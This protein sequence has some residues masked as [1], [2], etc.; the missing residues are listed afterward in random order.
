[1]LVLGI[2]STCD[3]TGCAIVRDGKEILSNVVASQHDIHA[4]YGGVFPELAS[5]RH[6]EVMIPVIDS[7]LNKA[8]IS[9]N[10]VDLIAVAHGP[11]LLGA[12][13]VG[14]NAAKT[15][16]FSL[17][18][19]FI[20]INHVEAHIYAAIMSQHT[21]PSLPCL[22]VILSGA[23]TSIIYI[24]EIGSYELLAQTTDDAIGEAFDKVAKVMDIPYPGGPKI[25]ALAK[26]GDPQSYPLKAGQVKGRPLDFSFSGIKTGVLYAVKGQNGLIDGKDK[27]SKSD[28][29][30]IAASFQRIVF[31]DVITKVLKVASERDC[32]TIIFGG[33]VTNNSRLR[34]MFAEAAPNHY[35]CWPSKGL[36]LD[37][38]A[39]I[40]GLGYHRYL[41]QGTG[42]PYD[43]E[44]LTRIR[45]ST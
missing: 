43:L 36:S 25:E 12:L 15:M 14:L 38:A 32:Q 40:A 29:S 11:G 10:H 45:F 27:I 42:D 24:R 13:L 1:M 33:G 39:M 4:K 6:T 28:K 30:D 35:L 2:E 41:K 7:A 22:G 21:P 9:L 20:G 19:P 34:E 17:S 31:S 5:R 16:A 8:G 37:N 3:E 26:E 23:H 18:K 44:A